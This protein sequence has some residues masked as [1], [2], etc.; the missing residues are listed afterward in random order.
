MSDD[1]TRIKDIGLARQKWLNEHGIHTYAELAGADPNWI[2]EQ[3]KNEGKPVPVSLEL[4]RC[5]MEE[6]STMAAAP[7]LSEPS[8][9]VIPI[10]PQ[11]LLPPTEDGW[12]E[13]ASFYVSYQHK[14]QVEHPTLRTQVV[15]RTYADHIEA[16]DNQQWEGIEG[17]NLC[18]WIMS[19]VDTIVNEN[20]LA[21]VPLATSSGKPSS[22]THSVKPGEIR[23]VGIRVHDPVGGLAIASAGEL[24]KGAVHSQQPLTF[25]FSLEYQADNKGTKAVD[26][27][28]CR[29]SLYI[30]EMPGD[31]LVLKSQEISRRL[32]ESEQ[33]HSVETIVTL[34]I[35]AG[36]YRIRAVAALAN[37]TPVLGV[38]DVPL[39]QII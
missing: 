11:N 38:I 21:A 1:L 5:W 26:A 23:I 10:Q 2:C 19:H 33:T 4:V 25:N 14:R 3:L 22:I 20:H 31:K 6:A 36:L 37:Q 17:E 8:T 12:E 34:H 7:P 35:P 15:Y 24:F 32:S 39:L 30:Y 28:D 16:N 29:L 13:F 27:W 9:N 18:S